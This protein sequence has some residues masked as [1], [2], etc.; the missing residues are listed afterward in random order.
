MIHVLDFEGNKRLGVSEFGAVT[1]RDFEIVSVNVEF[2]KKKFS[3]RV[4]Y[5]LSLRRSGL[6]AAHSAQTEDNLLRHY[7][8]SPGRVSTFIDG[9]ETLR[10]GPW[11]DTKLIYRRLFKGLKSYELIDLISAFEL[12]AGLTSLAK[13]HCSTAMWGFHNAL[14]DALAAALLIQ[15][16]RKHFPDISPQDLASICT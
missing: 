3:E 14:F 8:A 12:H 4:E 15:N 13:K 6:L 10:W 7:W 1:L 5:F 11:I 16:L 9:G 2:C